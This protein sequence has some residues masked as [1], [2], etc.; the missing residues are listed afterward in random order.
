M[1]RY[2]QHFAVY[3]KLG[4]T[5]SRVIDSVLQRLNE[6]SNIFPRIVFHLYFFSF[7]PFRYQSSFTNSTTIY[8]GLKDDWKKKIA[9]DFRTFLLLN[10]FRNKKLYYTCRRWKKIHLYIS[11]LYSIYSPIAGPNV[12]WTSLFSSHQI[13]ILST[14]MRYL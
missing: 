12:L 8:S 2:S 6:L 3:R 10:F 5:I 11:I 4:Q 13:L 9:K 1:G 14:Q 7:M